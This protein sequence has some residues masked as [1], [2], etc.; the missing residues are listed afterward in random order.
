MVENNLG[1]NETQMLAFYTVAWTMHSED[2]RAF[3]QQ[4]YIDYELMMFKKALTVLR[5]EE[6]SLDAVSDACLTLMKRIST[7][8]QLSDMS[9]RRYIIITVEHASINRLR[10]MKRINQYSF[11]VD[12][13]CTQE[14][15]ANEMPIEEQII[16]AAEK[17]RLKKAI[18]KLS[19]KEQ[20]ILSMR[21]D[22]EL[23]YKQIAQQIGVKPQNI[24]G[25][26][27]RTY[28]HLR[29]ILEEVELN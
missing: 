13:E 11:T 18:Q 12:E 4:L 21:F 3:F 6:E 19:E 9:L 24:G 8:R 7:L 20:W 16:I 2:D 28:K 10:R 27:E 5:N 23:T 29:R 25:I 1:G 26:L 15:A 14:L 17:Q 22:E